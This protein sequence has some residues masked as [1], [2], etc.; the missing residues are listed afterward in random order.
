MKK[1]ALAPFVVTEENLSVRFVHAVAFPDRVNFAGEDV[2]IR[3]VQRP[4]FENE[5]ETIENRDRRAI[6]I[7]RGG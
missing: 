2:R 5:Q 6:R 4:W 1:R 3:H 7:H